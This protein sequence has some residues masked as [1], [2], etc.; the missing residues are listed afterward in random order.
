MVEVVV[1]EP[2]TNSNLS[3][4]KTSTERSR[5]RRG[6]NRDLAPNHQALSD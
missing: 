5:K 1:D 3:R 6:V 2:V 4:P